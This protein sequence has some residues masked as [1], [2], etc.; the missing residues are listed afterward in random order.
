[1]SAY[2]SKGQTSGEGGRQLVLSL[3]SGR[4]VM[5][6]Q[7]EMIANNNIAGLLSFNYLTADGKPSFYYETNGLVPLSEYIR[8]YGQNIRFLAETLM[9]ISVT[10]GSLDKFLLEEKCLLLEPDI[11]FIDPMRKGVNL[12]YLP[13]EP[14]EDR[15]A[16]FSDLILDLVSGFRPEDATGKLYCRRII[17]EVKK[18]GFRYEAFTDFLLDILCFSDGR[19]AGAAMVPSQSTA[20]YSG[21]GP[22]GAVEKRA[23]AKQLLGGFAERAKNILKA[24]KDGDDKKHDTDG[25]AAPEG[26]EKS[27]L[28]LPSLAATAIAVA[29]FCIN[30][31]IPYDLPDAVTYRGGML[32]AALGG[33][34][35]LLMKFITGAVAVVGAVGGGGAVAA[36]GDRGVAGGSGGARG[37]AGAGTPARKGKR[38]KAIRAAS[39]IHSASI[40]AD[41]ASGQS[42]PADIWADSVEKSGSVTDE[43]IVRRVMDIDETQFVGGDMPGAELEN[44]PCME[45]YNNR[46][47]HSPHVTEDL[48]TE[49]LSI[50]KNSDATLLVKNTMREYGVTHSEDGFIIG[51]KKEYA[52]LVLE[53]PAIG[54]T[55]AKLVRK[56]DIWFL[57]DLYSKNGTFL[58]NIKLESGGEKI[59]SNSDIITIVNIDILFTLS[60]KA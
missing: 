16:L 4:S 42:Y 47:G 53:N 31:L 20:M 49:V 7:I 41:G 52:D 8:A 2:Y 39:Q 32:V 11:I 18:A 25:A 26:D 44:I 56:D 34:A 36:G 14:P 60:I 45:T 35:L 10:I 30:T 3:P 29:Y 27:N 58:N 46:V 15:Q 57:K 43:E 59:I 38:S 17:E 9:E 37:V 40:S 1:M 24:P 6:Y 33:E 22:A 55:H 28:L 54:K 50:S 13:V 19:Q 12:V 23:S 48:L 21:A 51:R 5:D